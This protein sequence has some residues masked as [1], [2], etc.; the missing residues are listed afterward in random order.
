[1]VFMSYTDE[2]RRQRKW[3]QTAIQ[4]RNAIDSYLPLQRRET[5]KFLLDLVQTPQAFENHVKR[6]AQAFL[7]IPYFVLSMLQVLRCHDDGDCLWPFSILS[8]RRVCQICGQRLDR[9]NRG[10]QPCS[11]LGRFLPVP[12]VAPPSLTLILT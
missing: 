10:R 4:A 8:R 2:W 7:R 3:Y 11:D 6:H 5:N 9:R 1:M 12:Y